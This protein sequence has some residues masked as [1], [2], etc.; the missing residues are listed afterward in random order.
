MIV[1]WIILLPA[2]LFPVKNISPFPA[3]PETAVVLLR[4]SYRFVLETRAWRL[5]VAG[6]VFPC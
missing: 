6:N 4:E 2:L 1:V 5:C 3:S